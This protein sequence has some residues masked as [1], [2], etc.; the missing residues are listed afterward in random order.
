MRT[1]IAAAALLIL[2]GAAAQAQS[3]YDPAMTGYGAAPQGYAGYDGASSGPMYR[4]PMVGYDQAS[5]EPHRMHSAY[6]PRVRWHSGYAAGYAG[7]EGSTG[8][9]PY[10]GPSYNQG[11]PVVSDVAAAGVTTV[12]GIVGFGLGGFS[13]WGDQGY[14]HASVGHCGCRNGWNF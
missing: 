1:F 3:S 10:T 8:Y 7:A 13:N 9:Q 5:R 2:T 4:H 12:A 11:I 14:G 6:G